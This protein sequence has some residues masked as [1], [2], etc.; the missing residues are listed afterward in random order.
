MSIRERSKYESRRWL[1]AL[2]VI[3]TVGLGGFGGCAGTS[4][5][6][7]RPSVHVVSFS[8]DVVL[9]SGRPVRIVFDGPV[10]AEGQVGA[11]LD[12]GIV[13]LVPSEGPP[14]VVSAVFLNPS[15]LHLV[16]NREQSELR[17][18]TRYRVVFSEEFPVQIAESDEA[19]DLS[20]VHEPLTLRRIGRQRE[21]DLTPELVLEAN[22]GMSI[23]SVQRA[24]RIFRTQ[25]PDGTEAAPSEGVDVRA[26]VREQ[27]EHRY[28]ITSARPLTPGGHYDL[29]CEDLTPEDGEPL[30][31]FAS[32]FVVRP[33]L[34]IR[35]LAPASQE[36][37]A[38]VGPDEV[39]L[40]IETTTQIEVDRVGQA[41]HLEPAMPG[42]AETWEWCGQT[43]ICATVS[44]Q[45][46]TEYAIVVGEGL[47]DMWGQTLGAGHRAVFRTTV[48]PPRL[49]LET[50]IFALES[51]QPGYPVWSRHVESMEV[52]C[53]YVPKDRIAAVLTG[54]MNYD[55]WYSNR[56]GDRIGWESL[57]LEPATIA[58]HDPG[59][60]SRWKQHHLPITTRCGEADGNGVYLMEVR[61]DAVRDARASARRYG[62]QYPY[63]VLANVTNMGVL[64]KPGPGGGLVWVT[65]LESGR[66]VSGARVTVMTPRGR[67]VKRGRTDGEG[68]L[69]L[70]GTRELLTTR[71]PGDS[72]AGMEIDHWRWQRM[73]VVVEKGDDLAIV[74]GNWQ[75]GIQIWNFGV[76]QDTSRSQNGRIT[77]GFLL[78][79][80]GIYRPG[81]T[82][83]FRGLIREIQPGRTPRIPRERDVRIELSDSHGQRLVEQNV[84][85]DAYGAF[86]LDHTISPESPLGD[87][88]LVAHAGGKRF[89]ESFTVREVVPVR[90]EVVPRGSRSSTAGPGE[91]V[92]LGF[93]ARYL[94]GAPVPEANARYTV[95]YRDRFVRFADYPSYVFED[96]SLSGGM[97][98][99]HQEEAT[100]AYVTDGSVTTRAD[101]SFEV[102]FTADQ[103]LGR[104]PR[105]YV[106]SVRVEDASEDVVT[107]R[108]A[109]TVHPTDFYVGLHTQESLQA[110]GMPFAVNA[111]A[112]TPAGETMST[113]ATLSYVR[114]R[115]QCRPL[116]PPERGTTCANV[117]EP[118][119]TRSIRLQAGGESTQR[120][121]PEEA[122]EFIIMLEAQDGRGRRVVASSHVWVLGEG[123][124]FWSGDESVRMSLIQ[125]AQRYDVGDTARLVPQADL[126]LG[127]T[128]VT[129]ERSGVIDARV[130]QL[131]RGVSAIE[132]PV[133]ESMAP[134]VFVSVASVRG[135]SGE[136][137]AG[138]PR[139]QMGVTNLE[140]D[141]AANRLAI[142]I[143]TERE[144]YKPG[145]MVRGTI[146]VRAG[147]RGV[148][149]QVSL[150]AA[151]EGIL[152]LIR[153][154]TPD[155]MGTMY[156]P[157]GLGVENATNWNRIARGLAPLGFRDG[158]DG[159]D[160][161]GGDDDRT[162][163][164]FV[165]SAYWSPALTTNARGEVGFEFAAPDSLTAYRLMA[166]AADR[167]HRF[168]SAER[169]VRVKKDLMILPALP[170][171]AQ[172]G[173]R[174]E[175]A[176]SVRRYSD[177]P[178][179][180]RVTLEAEGIA[181]ETTRF[182]VPLDESGRGEVRVFG[183]VEAPS[184]VDTLRVRA[185]ASLGS[186][187]DSVEERLPV[188]R[189]VVHE[190]RVIA[191]NLARPTNAFETRVALAEGSLA[192]ESELEL[193]I[194]RFGAAEL[195]PSL[196]QLID[197]PYG[198]TE[199]TLSRMLALAVA[200]QL[201]RDLELSASAERADE[202]LDQGLAKLRRHQ[203]S[204]GLF[205]YWPAWRGDPH[206]TAYALVAL[207]ELAE[208]R[209]EIAQ[210]PGFRRMVSRSSQALHRWARGRRDFADGFQ[211][212]TLA[213]VFDGLSSLPAELRTIPARRRRPAQV[214][215]LDAGLVE[216]LF[217]ARSQLSL[218]ARAHLLRALGRESRFTAQASM[219][220]QEMTSGLRVDDDERVEI[221]RTARARRLLPSDARTTALL[222]VAIHEQRPGHRL[223]VPL[224]NALRALRAESG[225]WG[226]THRNA[227]AIYA[228]QRTAPRRRRAR[229]LRVRV[230]VGDEVLHDGP[231]ASILR[232]RRR[233]TSELVGQPVRVSA[234][235]GRFFYVARLDQVRG[236][237]VRP[238][239]SV[240]V[241]AGIELSTE[242]DEYDPARRDGRVVRRGV[243]FDS[244]ERGK[245]YLVR[246][247]VSPEDGQ[248]HEQVVVRVP[249]PAGL[250][251]ID[252]TLATSRMEEEWSGGYGVHRE[253]GE[254]E[255]RFFLQRLDGERQLSFLVRAVRPGTFVMPGAAAEGMYAPEVQGRLH[256]RSVS[257]SR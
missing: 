196:E 179:A 80:R 141:S 204:R 117:N 61:S 247:S 129:V 27:A 230:T 242:I 18:R 74:D 224:R 50:G 228:L 145:E 12:A 223:V 163:S 39:T 59:V 131:P 9:G 167:G 186:F 205:A 52:E 128:L 133:D 102:A 57:G 208:S 189:H 53:A 42:L 139:F 127:S 31:S 95:R 132:V 63:R 229:P 130:V 55:P 256:G 190:N 245:V 191:E 115:R 207:Q 157:F 140:V 244:F 231:V 38:E 146:R 222:L 36:G 112:L 125:S 87:Y 123:E 148:R 168:G 237:E 58:I 105:D 150:S 183:R 180:A 104:R 10:V 252:T 20:V 84:R 16:L 106:V 45:P 22:A 66:P 147:E 243:S 79:D 152:Q 138:R 118:V 48:A 26:A 166:V 149:A 110:A 219:L 221:P 43:R 44:L 178:G 142:E 170:R 214:I 85:L 101:G 159:D 40:A 76:R 206:L 192:E 116:P 187:V 54:E 212:N 73:I 21:V 51:S 97:W 177:A 37:I 236:G 72:G 182:D 234:S 137:D 90:F 171:F 6:D 199:Q 120:I 15:T 181:L 14:A 255:A 1:V 162:R 213:M 175:L 98:W 109:V 17:P 68:I 232:L 197:Y 100:P 8:S 69:R 164:R 218:A 249:V 126:S 172:L 119:W 154:R 161:A 81:E 46:E 144:E 67:V 156:S 30:E 246:T 77:R 3:A 195:A 4:L 188:R 240:A 86:S 185:R 91:T 253:L 103:E 49:H 235:A 23:E 155:P 56:G 65:S 47:Q 217:A 193:V 124:A 135:R 201:A 62:F 83:H 211:A 114:V 19:V 136:G 220:L 75:N 122:G 60:H 203:S 200:G 248:D 121:E 2:G 13:G 169:R 7:T 34:A 32:A 28:T 226:T 29:R 134:N 194:D 165:S 251:I 33:E 174:V 151:D 78:S 107:A 5:P 71:S 160:G 143:E 113:D 198:C 99:W 184:G 209:P 88:T 173:D 89:H 210:R 64:V 41:V 93:E 202:L 254:E 239:A 250:E 108:A 96:T 24:C 153:F 233:L 216:R 241:Q 257:V 94:Y 92:Q 111:V 70:P 25:D 238:E 225:H 11:P 35:E 158:E 82:A 227:H 215:E 176:F